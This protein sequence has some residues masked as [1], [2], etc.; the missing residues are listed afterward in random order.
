MLNNLSEGIRRCYD[1]A[2][3]AKQKA[4]KTID[5]SDINGRFS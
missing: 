4:E 1:R 2:E 5:R 3:E